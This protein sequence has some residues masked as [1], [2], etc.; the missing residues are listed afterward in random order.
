MS[1]TLC[2]HFLVP[3]HLLHHTCI[4]T[5]HSEDRIRNGA[6]KLEKHKEGATQGRL[7]TFFK[8]VPSPA[9]AAKRKVLTIDIKENLG[10]V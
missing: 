1:M 6:K 3:C 7:D 8:S 4:H 5:T 9:T 10:I 2:K